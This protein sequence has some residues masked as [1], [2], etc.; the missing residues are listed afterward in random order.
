VPKRLIFIL[1]SVLLLLSSVADIILGSVNIPLSKILDIVFDNASGIEREIV[2][3]IRMPKMLSAILSGAALGIS[4]LIMQTLFRNPLA[5]PYILGISSGA[6]LGVSIVIM[7]GSVIGVSM[8]NVWLTIGAAIVGAMLV[9]VAVLTVSNIVKN[10]VS[11]LIIGMMIGN[12][13]SS[14]V[15]VIQNYSNPDALKLFILWTFGSLESVNW[16]QFKILCPLVLIGITFSI[17]MIKALN[18]MLLGDNYAD[19]MGI[20]IKRSRVLIIITT[21]LLAG[22]VTAFVGPIAFIGVAVPH[23]AR[24]LMNSDDHRSLLPATILIG[25]IITLWCDIL[26]HSFQHPLPISTVSAMIGAP[27]IIYILVKRQ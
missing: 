14:I 4:G 5:G 1:L 7:L 23:I 25:A 9:L 17:Y 12:I 16:S 10:S 8:F 21:G 27:I 15:G 18:A 24:G 6:T 11:L 19:S 13:A 3:N 22:S 26:S 2:L 20:D